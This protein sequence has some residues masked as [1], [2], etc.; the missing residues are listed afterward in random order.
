VNYGQT[1]AAAD[2]DSLTTSLNIDLSTARS[3]AGN[4]GLTLNCLSRFALM[5]GN[6]C[7]QEW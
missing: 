3:D 5:L 6:N 1:I 4:L 7:Q 2:S